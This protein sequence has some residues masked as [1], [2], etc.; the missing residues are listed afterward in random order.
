MVFTGSI[1]AAIV[2]P[3]DLVKTRLQAQVTGSKVRHA[4]C[5]SAFKDVFNEGGLKALY[6]GWLPNVLRAMF[7]TCAQVCMLC[8]MVD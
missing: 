6:T 3:T 4:G 8:C 5:I 7:G 1:G 2:T